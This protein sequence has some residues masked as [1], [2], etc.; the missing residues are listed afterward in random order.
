MKN[1]VLASAL[2]CMLIGMASE[3]HAG[4][5]DVEAWKTCE[6]LNDYVLQ[7][8]MRTSLGT[9]DPGAFVQWAEDNYQKE[10]VRCRKEYLGW[11]Y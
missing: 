2:T 4:T 1:V 11:K 5:Y 7:I 3:G 6:A 10:K 9:K 8:Q